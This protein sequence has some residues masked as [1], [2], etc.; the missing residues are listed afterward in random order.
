MQES[1]QESSRLWETILEALNEGAAELEHPPD[2]LQMIDSTVVRAHQHAA[3]AR[4]EDSATGYWALKRWPDDQDPPPR[5]NAWGLPTR[6]DV[7]PGQLSDHKGFGLVMGDD[8]RAPRVLLAD[9]GYDADRIRD[10]AEA[11][12][13]TPVIPMSRNR[14]TRAGVDRTFYALRNPSRALLWEAQEA[15]DDALD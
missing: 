7:T 8:L 4:G 13:A 9:K 15:E 12:D 5:C 3:G 14:K 11:R 6:T 1:R 2:R 10:W